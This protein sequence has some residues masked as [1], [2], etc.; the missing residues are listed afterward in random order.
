MIHFPLLFPPCSEATQCVTLYSRQGTTE[1]IEEVED[2]QDQLEDKAQ[3]PVEA[4]Q[5]D[6]EPWSDGEP[7]AM[8]GKDE[9]G[10]ESEREGEAEESL[11][12]EGK[13]AAEMAP[14]ESFGPDQ[15]LPLGVEEPEPALSAPD[16]EFTTESDE[17]DQIRDFLQPESKT[18]LLYTADTD[19]SKTSDTDVPPSYSKA[20]SFDRLE[21]SDDDSDVDRRRRLLMTSDS[22]SDSRSDIVLPSMTTELTASELLLNK[23]G[24]IPTL[25]LRARPSVY[26]FIVLLPFQNV[27]RRGAGP[28]GPVLPEAAPGPPALLR[29]LQHVG[30]S[31]GDGVLPGHHHQPHGVGLLRHPGASHLHLPVGHA[32]GAPAQQALLDDG[33]HLHRGLLNHTVLGADFFFK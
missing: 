33:Y 31:F 27:L 4:Q 7:G 11:D 20:V 32:V 10:A 2:E 24:H 14:W 19:A 30:G 26:I 8:E 22:R 21:V 3:A 25:L 5:L 6:G 9:E 13:D 18:G 16:K 12:Q 15:G 28:L 17:G 29:P 23:Y 1:T